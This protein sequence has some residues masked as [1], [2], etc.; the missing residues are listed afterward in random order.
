MTSARTEMDSRART[1]GELVLALVEQQLAE[2]GLALHHH[3]V[4]AHNLLCKK[5]AQDSRARQRFSRLASKGKR[6][7]LSHE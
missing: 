1:L 3:A 7:V 6:Q 5:Q 2:R 4:L